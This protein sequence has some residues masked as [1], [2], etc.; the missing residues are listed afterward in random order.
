M[1]DLNLK[2]LPLAFYLVAAMWLL[3]VAQVLLPGDLGHFGIV[4]RQLSG[5]IGIPLA[6]FIHH[7]WMHLISNSIPFLVLGTLLQ[8]SSKGNF[9][10]ITIIL[11]VVGGLGTWLLGSAGY[12]AGASGLVFGFWAYLLADAYYSRSI[13]SAIIAAVVFLLYGGLIFSLI[14]FRPHISWV[15]HASGM[16]AGVLVARYVSKTKKA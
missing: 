6:P 11:T 12:H 13:K 4:P 14:D 9:W 7:G 1:T 16:V 5:L 2:N 3:H 15:G 10:D 8:Y